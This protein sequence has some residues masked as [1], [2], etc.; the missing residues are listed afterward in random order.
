MS[1]QQRS[2]FRLNIL[3]RFVGVRTGQVRKH[4]PSPSQQRARFFD[5]H[6][7]VFEGRLCVLLRDGIDFIQLLFHACVE[8]RLKMFNLD[9]VERRSSQWQSTWNCEGVV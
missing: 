8:C 3:Q 6:D 1:G 5:G 7:C 2:H 4:L 9:F